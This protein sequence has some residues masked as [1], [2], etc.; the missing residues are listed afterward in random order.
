MT[1]REVQDALVDLHDGRLD[2][3]S[4][5][6]VHAH[7]ETCADCRDQAERWNALLPAMRGLAP[8]PPTPMRA[9]RMEIEIER[10]L[11]EPVAR[12]ARPRRRWPLFAVPLAAAAALALWLLPHR[13]EAP[14]VAP[15]PRPP[16]RRSPS[17]LPQTHPRANVSLRAAASSCRRDA[18]RR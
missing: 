14:I 12:A 3:A 8:P 16:H 7:L 15:A 10:Q 13:H 2:A 18:A 11:A 9:R 17:S 1:C 4:E 6:R 5:L